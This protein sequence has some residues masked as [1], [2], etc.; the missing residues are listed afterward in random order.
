LDLDSVAIPK[1]QLCSDLVSRGSPCQGNA[2]KWQVR[3]STA[4]PISEVREASTGDGY[5]RVIVS[6]AAEAIQT[7]SQAGRGIRYHAVSAAW[8]GEGWSSM[9]PLRESQPSAATTGGRGY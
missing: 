4:L 3:S 2:L 8:R 5:W 7:I 9:I 6:V 1:A